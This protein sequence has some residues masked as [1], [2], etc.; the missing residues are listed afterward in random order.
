[1]QHGTNLPPK[2][3][4]GTNLLPQMQH[5]TNLLPKH[6]GEDLSSLSQG[7]LVAI[8]PNRLVAILSG[9]RSNDRCCHLQ[10]HQQLLAEPC[11]PVW[12]QAEA[13]HC[14]HPQTYRWTD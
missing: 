9:A 10:V 7:Q 6:A 12:Q 13:L 4:H 3:Q 14:Y 2:L 1:L 11:Q 8:H 5:G